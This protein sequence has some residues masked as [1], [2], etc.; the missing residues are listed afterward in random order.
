MW[1]EEMK[2]KT[3]ADNSMLISSS[4]KLNIRNITT[5]K[6]NKAKEM[7]FPHSFCCFYSYNNV[8]AFFR[9]TMYKKRDLALW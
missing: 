3:K 1:N 4:Q 9:C 5:F 6:V 2:Y 8:Y 7:I